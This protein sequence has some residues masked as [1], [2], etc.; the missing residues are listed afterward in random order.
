M[1][2]EKKNMDSLTA[3]AGGAS[4]GVALGS[5]LSTNLVLPIFLGLVGIALS[6]LVDSSKKNR[7]NGEK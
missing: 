5:I 4:I 2:D 6:C 1:D 7:N 3:K